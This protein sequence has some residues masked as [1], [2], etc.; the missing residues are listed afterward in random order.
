[1]AKSRTFQHRA[2]TVRIGTNS[3]IQTESISPSEMRRIEE[4]V[5]VV[6]SPRNQILQG[7]TTYAEAW[8]IR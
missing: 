4:Q 2:P 8:L 6:A 5:K 1:M 3:G 7:F